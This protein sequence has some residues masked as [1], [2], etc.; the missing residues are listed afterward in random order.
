MIFCQAGK[1]RFIVLS[2][3]LTVL[4]FSGFCLCL[5]YGPGGAEN[6]AGEALK[7]LGFG[8]AKLPA[9]QRSWTHISYSDI[10]LD[11]DGISTIGKLDIG[12]N[13]FTILFSGRMEVLEIRNLGII[14]EWD[15]TGD[16]P[17]SFSGWHIPPDF[18]SLATL[19][20][21]RIRIEQGK[22]SLLTPGLGGLSVDFDLEGSLKNKKI[23]FQ[24][25]VK[26]LQ[27][28]ISVVANCSG[29]IARDY[30]DID[31]DIDE[32]KFDVPEA[33]IRASRA[34]GWLNYTRDKSGSIKTMAELRAGGLTVLDLPWQNASATVELNNGNLQIF[35]GAKSTGIEDIELG[36]NMQQG[37]GKAAIVYGN[38]HADSGAGLAEY[39]Q[40]QPKIILPK[41]DMTI[42]R[43]AEDLKADFTYDNQKIRYR[44]NTM[45]NAPVH[46]IE[47][48]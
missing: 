47:M 17:A 34:Y 48:K 5:A 25:H 1:T 3:L 27:K 14:G 13:P 33:G 23:E 26:S 24:S 20:T 22:I 35:S 36:L 30:S 39:L 41:A 9:P 11:K 2:F 32:G 40:Q 18:Q 4:V 12:Y 38:I 37:P 45:E 6:A 10:K 19:P 8:E 29:V 42:I 28:Y 21:R 16:P 46:E 44:L 7:I 15:A 31:V 43:H